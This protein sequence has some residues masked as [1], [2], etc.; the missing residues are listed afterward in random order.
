MIGEARG[1]ILTDNSS[2]TDCIYV[3]SSLDSNSYDELNISTVSSVTN[4]SENTENSIND[5]D[6]GSRDDVL[7]F[8]YTNADYVLNKMD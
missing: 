5:S 1:V 8:Y 2:D 6:L 4:V 3:N 7:K